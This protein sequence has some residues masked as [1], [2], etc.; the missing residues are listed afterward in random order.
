MSDDITRLQSDQLADLI[1]KRHGLGEEWVNVGITIQSG[2]HTDTRAGWVS[3][4]PGYTMY[5]AKFVRSGDVLEPLFEMTVAGTRIKEEAMF[6]DDEIICR[7]S[8]GSL[9]PSDEPHSEA[10]GGQS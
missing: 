7:G 9:R 3:Q 5:E 4:S 2:L 6:C 10:T 1:R 8:V